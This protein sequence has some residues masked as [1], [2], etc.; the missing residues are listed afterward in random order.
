M[1]EAERLIYHPELKTEMKKVIQECT[2]CCQTK[3]KLKEPF[4]YFHLVTSSPFQE[5][6]LDFLG[7]MPAGAT[8]C[9]Y[10]LVMVDTLTRYIIAV[11]TV[12]RTAETVISSLQKDLFCPFDV[13]KSMR[14]DNAKEFR[15]EL[16][17]NITT[18]YGIRLAF[19][20]P[21]H[22]QGNGI[23]EASVK[24]VLKALR[25]FCTE[26]DTK[27]W[28][29]VIYDAV[30]FINASYNASIGDSP[31]FALFGRDRNHP[32]KLLEV[33]GNHNENV[34][35]SKNQMKQMDDF[36]QNHVNDATAM[37]IISQNR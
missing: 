10:V 31:F 6:S 14:M 11:P 9:R 28:D 23:A 3:N 7:P 26:K 37:K 2:N 20:S 35:A 16:L 24:K 33:H 18:A 8:G 27:T 32:L 17:Q 4:L 21:Y 29:L 1:L 19:S 34:I 12:D 25:L 5:V 30:S 13:P 22:P 15:S 36:L